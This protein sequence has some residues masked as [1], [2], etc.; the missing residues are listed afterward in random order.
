MVLIL[1]GPF[2]L[3]QLLLPLLFSFNHGLYTLAPVKYNTI[4]PNTYVIKAYS[5]NKMPLSM[6]SLTFMSLVAYVIR[7]M[8]HNITK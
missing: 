4:C 5:I 7:H 1:L 6:V 3:S 2:T 8:P